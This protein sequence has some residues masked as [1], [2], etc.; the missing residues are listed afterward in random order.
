M[1]AP[2]DL[3]ALATVIRRELLGQPGVAKLSPCRRFTSLYAAE[4]PSDSLFFLESGLVKLVKRGDAG[5]EIVVDLIAPGELF[6]EQ[7]I[8]VS[9]PR[10]VGAEM[11]ETGTAYVIPR[12]TFRQFAEANTEVWKLLAESIQRRERS[13]QRKIE[14]LCLRDVEQRILLML[15]DLAPRIGNRVPGGYEYSIPLSQSELASLIGATRETTST[16]LNHLERRGLIHLG[17]RLLV[18]NS[19]E[20]ALRAAGDALQAAATSN[21]G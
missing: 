8:W 14:L 16:T 6:G 18:I 1:Q 3:T 20:S 7:G 15:A 5:K 9:Q 12:E 2:Y 19:V 4:S 13:L 17:R 11:L 21:A 10:L